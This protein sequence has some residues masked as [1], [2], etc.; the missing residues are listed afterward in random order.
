MINL[1]SSR[2]TSTSRMG[3]TRWRHCKRHNGIEKR[4]LERGLMRTLWM[5]SIKSSFWDL[6]ISSSVSSALDSSR[7]RT[8][9]D[10]WGE[11][12]YKDGQQRYDIKPKIY[13]KSRYQKC[14]E[15]KGRVD[16]ENTFLGWT[17]T[18]GS[19][20]TSAGSNSW[21]WASVDGSLERMRSIA[22]DTYS[23]MK[24]RYYPLV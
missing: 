14:L 21:T 8:R 24:V 13:W 4:D 5:T 9:S 23:R 7:G 6:R 2:A 19:T 12:T 17:S 1:F 18:S 22:W 11:S 15:T 10:W 3:R 20:F 16:I